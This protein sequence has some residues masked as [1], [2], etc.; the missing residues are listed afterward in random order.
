M[1]ARHRVIG[2]GEFGQQPFHLVL[3]QRHVHLDRRM[4]GDRSRNSGTYLFQIQRLLFARE[5]IQQ[6]MQHILDRGCFHSRRG[7]FHRNAARAKWLGLE[8]IAGQFIRNFLKNSLLRRGQL[9]HDRHQQSLAFHLHGCSLLQHS[10]KQDALMGDVLIH[11]PESVFIHGE[12]KRVPDLPQRL[13]RAQRRKRRL[14][15][16]YVERQ[17]NIHDRAPLRLLDEQIL[18][19]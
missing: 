19:E 4:A 12:N 7:D 17:E 3:F 11:N 6:F 16:A 18:P 9:Q 5:L 13:Q 8:S 2:L 10:F 15:F 14:F 1:W